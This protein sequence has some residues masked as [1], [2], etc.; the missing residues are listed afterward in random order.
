VSVTLLS[1]QTS[2]LRMPPWLVQ[3]NIPLFH[4]IGLM[5]A[6][7]LLEQDYRQSGND[8]KTSRRMVKRTPKIQKYE[9]RLS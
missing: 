4:M 6:H 8:A 7:A 3:P 5:V 1:N 2:H 9:V